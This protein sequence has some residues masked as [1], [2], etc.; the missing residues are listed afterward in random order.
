MSFICPQTCIQIIFK[1]SSSR[2]TSGKYNPMF[3]SLKFSFLNVS[4]RFSFFVQPGSM[5]LNEMCFLLCSRDPRM[6]RVR[7]MEMVSL[8]KRQYLLKFAHVD[9]DQC[10]HLIYL[11]DSDRD[12]G[13]YCPPVKRERTSSLTQFPPSHSGEH[14]PSIPST[15]PF[16]LKRSSDFQVCFFMKLIFSLFSFLL[17][18]QFPRI[19]S[20]CPQVYASLQ[21]V[22]PTRNQVRNQY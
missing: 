9:S 21:L 3:F 5:W 17:C 4:C 16:I 6:G 18:L 12:D 10:I 11:L 13:E 7:R 1:T 8:Q 19:I 2:S 14:A 20:L 22:I 15:Q